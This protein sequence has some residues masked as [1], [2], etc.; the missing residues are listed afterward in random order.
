M[1]AH[2]D[3]VRGG[4][5]RLVIGSRGDL[6]SRRQ[7]RRI[8]IKCA[9]NAT[10]L[11]LFSVGLKGRKAFISRLLGRCHIFFLHKQGIVIP[12]ACA[13]DS[14]ILSLRI[15]IIIDTKFMSIL[16]YPSCCQ[17]K[18]VHP[19]CMLVLELIIKN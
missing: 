19:V 10:F 17:E 6:A 18:C 4:K 12:K 2:G 3:F 7:R 8:P 15:R 1:G 16:L 13:E 9:V 14:I 5:G 11:Q